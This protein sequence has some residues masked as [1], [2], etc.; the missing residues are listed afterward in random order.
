MAASYWSSW[1]HRYSRCILRQPSSPHLF[2]DKEDRRTLKFQIERAS[3]VPGEERCTLHARCDFWCF[4]SLSTP[5]LSP[6]APLGMG[7]LK[8]LPGYYS[9]VRSVPGM[10]LAVYLAMH[11]FNFV[12]PPSCRSAGTLLPQVPLLALLE[13]R[14]GPWLPSRNRGD[15]DP[16]CPR[17]FVLDCAVKEDV[18]HTSDVV[19]LCPCTIIYSRRSSRPQKMRS[20][21]DATPCKVTREERRLYRSM[22]RVSFKRSENRARLVRSLNS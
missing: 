5:C 14:K 8:A 20:G 11:V 18:C 13:L 22:C 19:R 1:A 3:A 4:S 9:S 17:P 15:G 10:G 21:G 2:V 7:G 16:C 12:Y 6:S